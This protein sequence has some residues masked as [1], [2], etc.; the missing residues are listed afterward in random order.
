MTLRSGSVFAGYRIERT[1]GSGGMGT[2][3]LARHPRLPRSVALKVLD[4]AAGADAEFRARFQREAELAAR[5]DH[6]NIVEIYDRGSEEGRLWISMRYVAGADVAQLIQRRS[7][8]LPPSRVIEI[9]AQAADGLDAAHR[10]GLL[11]RDVKPANLLVAAGDEG[12][13][14]VFV[15]DFGIARSRDDTS[16]LTAAGALIA[17]LGYV[18]PEQIRGEPLDHRCDVY[19]LGAT[20]YQMLTGAM[21]FA[22]TTPAAVLRAHLAEPP[23]RPSAADPALPAALDVVVA[24]AMSKRPADRYDSCR[25]LAVAAA[26]AFAPPPAPRLAQPVARPRPTPPVRSS[27]RVLAT[28]AAVSVLFLALAGV[29]LLRSNT[30]PGVGIADSATPSASSTATA[31]PSSTATTA[32]SSAWGRNAELV[33]S[34]P[35][36]LPATPD[37]FGYQGARCTDIDVVNNGGAPAVECR[38]DNG[39]HWYVWSFRRGDPRRDSTF[40]TNI[41]NDTT[42]QEI[43][44]RPSGSGR[45]RWSHYPG[46]NTGLLTVGFD[47]PARA[48]IVIDVSW[49]HHTGQE[50]FDQWWQSA[51]L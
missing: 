2:V 50:L 39:I 25:A 17:T 45:V 34:L 32:A 38:Q 11:H 24:T 37:G 44:R 42:R 33:A 47:D 8:E 7:H 36:L 18:A 9:L 13:D 4:P 43:W 15:T 51:P 12:R 19:A 14:H 27:P 30:V 49:D 26:Q 3:Y 29:L 21:P 31:A 23:P 22:R 28:T 16:R 1:L 41:D 20:L 10:R 46:G 6:P 40:D 5:L 35:G 48:W